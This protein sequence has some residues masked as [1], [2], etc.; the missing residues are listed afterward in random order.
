MST[1]P[2]IIPAII[3]ASAPELSQALQ[4]LAGLPAVHIDVVDGVFAT[5]TSW[6]Y[7]PVGDP[8]SLKLDFD[9]F[10]L[11]VD[12]MVEDPLA[13]AKAWSLAGAD[14]LVFHCESIRVEALRAFVDA[15]TISVG[16]CALLD[17]PK[18][19]LL[20]Y[21]ELADYVQVM[22]IV[23]IG[24]QGQPFAVEVF[25]RIVWLQK[26]APELPISIDGGVNAIT[27]PIIIP[28]HLSRYIV[29]SAIIRQA[30]PRQAYEDL[31]ALWR[32]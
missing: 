3:P 12:L 23:K 21:L 13:A 11:E 10:S 20:P 30:K 2:P 24:Q 17:T 6:P 28:Y 18:E 15:T 16:V 5:T 9:K 8:K 14:R 29:G 19:R 7:L 4:Q 31:V 26:I 32:Q 1:C 27:L 22:G 25:D